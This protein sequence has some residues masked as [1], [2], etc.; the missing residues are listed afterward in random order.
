MWFALLKIV[1]KWAIEKFNTDIPE[2]LQ[3]YKINKT[4]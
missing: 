1:F 2:C 3:L 4:L